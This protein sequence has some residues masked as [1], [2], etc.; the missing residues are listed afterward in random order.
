[1]I[2]GFI[3]TKYDI[4]NKNLMWDVDGDTGSKAGVTDDRKYTVDYT[5]NPDV[6]GKYK[7][8]DTSKDEIKEGEDYQLA[9]GENGYYILTLTDAEGNEHEVKVDSL[10]AT[11]VDKDG[12]VYEVKKKDG[13]EN[14]VELSE[15]VTSTEASNNS[16]A[17]RIRNN[18][19]NNGSKFTMLISAAIPDIQITTQDSIKLDSLN[20]YFEGRSNLNVQLK[21]DSIRPDSIKYYLKL[22]DYSTNLKNGSKVIVKKGNNKVSELKIET[23]DAPYVKFDIGNSF[24]GEYFF[25]KGFDE[26]STLKS[27]AYYD[28]IH[29]K[30]NVYYAPV[31][32]LSVGS[33]AT[34]KINIEDFT[35]KIKDDSGFRIKLKAS[36]LGKITIGGQADSISF[37][38]RGLDS[39]KN[40]K[41]LTIRSIAAINGQNIVPIFIDATIEQTGK[42]V[43][44]L[45]YYSA[46]EVNRHVKLIYTK[47]KDESSYPSLN[48][49]TV[50][51][52][53]NNNSWNQLF[54]NYTIDTMRYASN[55]TTNQFINAGSFTD[56]FNRLK[57][58]LVVAGYNLTTIAPTINDDY[59]FITNI[60]LSNKGGGHLPNK[61][62]GISLKF[63]SAIGETD[64]EVI[65]HELGHWLGLIH[66]FES[67]GIFPRITN[68]GNTKHN[69]MDY[70]IRR[71]RWYKI[72]LRNYRR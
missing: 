54:V 66:P 37:T 29:V 47:L 26:Q 41:S 34:I 72:Q 21:R 56:G 22:S 70:D 10:P 39:L 27:P 59:Y 6:A 13:E 28:T 2:D 63:S 60:Q 61:K 15:V 17:F 50:S 40:I 8:I 46:E 71:Y 18:I 64:Q 33:S 12:N 1:M 36:E 68:Q 31:L 23:Y 25:D 19:Y 65:A 49:N 44:R 62:G 11:I 24:N 9:K 43:G 55:L 48:H 58:S 30:G 3:E 38:A 45:E 53:L 20:Y 35:D 32:G 51:T 69:F 5:L 42:R 4:S 14:E 7:Y 52:F 67:L 16:V 57:D